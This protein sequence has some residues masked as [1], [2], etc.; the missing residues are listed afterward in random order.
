MCIC[1]CYQLK[2]YSLYILKMFDLRSMQN[3]PG[4]EN[5][6]KVSVAKP[7]WMVGNLAGLKNPNP[8]ANF[9]NQDLMGMQSSTRAVKSL[10][11]RGRLFT[12]NMSP[13]KVL[14]NERLIDQAQ[15]QLLENQQNNNSGFAANWTHREFDDQGFGIIRPKYQNRMVQP[16][17]LP[18]GVRNKLTHQPEVNMVPISSMVGN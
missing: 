3:A 9:R 5:L 18:A 1:V 12:K 10:D 17:P 7:A 6:G 11:P 14:V 4:Y 2:F 13:G 16:K 15:A 8:L